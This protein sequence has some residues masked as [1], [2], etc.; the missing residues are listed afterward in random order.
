MGKRGNVVVLDIGTSAVKGIAVRSSP[1]GFEVLGYAQT[2]TRGIDTSGIKDAVALK[3]SVEAVLDEI[4][5]QIGRTGY[6]EIR[7]VFSDDSY[8]ISRSN[9]EIDLDSEGPVVIDETILRE[10][11]SSLGG[12]KGFEVKPTTVLHVFPMQYTLDGTRKVI[13]PLELEAQKLSVDAYTATVSSA[14]GDSIKQILQGIA[15]DVLVSFYSPGIA[16]GYATTTEAEREQGSFVV[17]LG[18]S[19]VTVTSFVNSVP[20]ALA[21]S[22]LG[23]KYVIKDVAKVLHTSIAEAERLVKNFGHASMNLPDANTEIDYYGLDGRTRRKIRKHELS[24]VIYARL[25]EILNRARKVAFEI[26]SSSTIPFVEFAPS[27]VILTGG[28]AKLPGVVD[29][30]AEVFKGFVRTGNPEGGSH[31]P[32]EGPDEVL[33]DPIYSA[34]VGALMVESRKELEQAPKKKRTGF[35]DFL[36]ELFGW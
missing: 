34:C 30:S 11:L 25:R 26:L 4:S 13:N 32:V 23:F 17:D 24:V 5:T 29:T 31:T 2:R 1:S 33:R 35:L 27:S 18:H 14:K 22:T 19:F 16:A 8:A 12:E 3:E 36:R 10:L 9:H 28:G 15:G 6:E 7:A 21:V 20:V